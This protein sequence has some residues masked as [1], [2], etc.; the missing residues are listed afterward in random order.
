MP[1]LIAVGSTQNIVV[2]KKSRHP[3]NDTMKL[4]MMETS[5]VGEWVVF[6]EG[7]PQI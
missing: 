6:I 3:S 7:P 2:K 1:K 4:P 5:P